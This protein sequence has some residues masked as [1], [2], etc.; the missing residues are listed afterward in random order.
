MKKFFIIPSA[1]LTTFVP[2]YGVNYIPVAV[3][4]LR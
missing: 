1:F 4:A 2:A 3:N